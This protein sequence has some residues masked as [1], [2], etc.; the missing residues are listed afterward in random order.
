MKLRTLLNKFTN[1]FFLLTIDGVCEEW[2]GGVEEIKKE[3]Y[4]K[5]YR[6]KKVLGIA[7]LTTNMQPELKIRIEK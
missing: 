2:Y 3:D 7:I 1:S 4:Y 5:E 6:D